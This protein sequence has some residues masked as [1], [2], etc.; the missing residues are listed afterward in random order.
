MQENSPNDSAEKRSLSVDEFHS[1]DDLIKSRSAMDKLK[2]IRPFSE[3]DLLNLHENNYLL[4]N[5][6]FIDK[7]IEV[8]C[9]GEFFLSPW[10]DHCS[11]NCALTNSLPLFF[12]LS[13]QIRT[14][15]M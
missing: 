7:F 9:A 2:T 13:A 11:P 5:G 8:K 3:C 1:I 15:Y 10:R 4:E 6:N 12:K 14:L